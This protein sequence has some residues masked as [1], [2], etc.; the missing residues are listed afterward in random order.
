MDDV[1]KQ[2]VD[3]ISS[4]NIFNNLYPGGLFI[5]FLRSII[6][7]NLLSEN[8]IENLILLYFTGMVL[9]RIGSILIEPMMKKLK[10]ISYAPYSDYISASNRDHL[11]ETLSEVN[12]TYRTLVTTFICLVICRIGFLIN[13]IYVKDRIPFL[14]DSEDWI[15]LGLMIFLF[16]VSYVK[17]TSYIRNRVES[18]LKY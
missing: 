16:I 18:I 15:F 11:L 12:N 9:S 8:W 1:L 4:Y 6:E 10:L 3:K 7:I 13:E 14:E 2:I 5:Y 17:Q